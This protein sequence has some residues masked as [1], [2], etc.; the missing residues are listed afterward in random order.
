MWPVF[1]GYWILHAPHLQHL[2][3]TGHLYLLR[4]WIWLHCP[5][6]SMCQISFL[7]WWRDQILDQ[8]KALNLVLASGLILAWMPFWNLMPQAKTSPFQPWAGQPLVWMFSLEQHRMQILIALMQI[9]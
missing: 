4:K 3:L 2:G 9:F 7:Q 6:L 5:D 8:Q 1:L